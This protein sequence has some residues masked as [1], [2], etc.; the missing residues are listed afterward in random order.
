M[1]FVTLSEQQV[2]C[3]KRLP[4]NFQ[5]L[6]ATNYL[7]GRLIFKQIDYFSGRKILPPTRKQVA[8]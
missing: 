6:M 8:K 1:K 2:Q 5:I 7:F 4:L 3:T